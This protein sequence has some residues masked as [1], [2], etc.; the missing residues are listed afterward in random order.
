MVR[1]CKAGHHKR[2]SSKATDRTLGYTFQQLPSNLAI[3]RPPY[4]IHKTLPNPKT[5]PEIHPESSSK[6]EIQKKYTKL[7]DFR[8]FFV[9]F[10]YFGFGG[11]FGVYFGVYFGF[12]G[13][14]CILYGGRMITNQI[15]N[16][17]YLSV[18]RNDYLC[19]GVCSAYLKE[20]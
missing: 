13:V 16:D 7:G 15:F 5:H 1:D 12:G 20:F 2:S 14:L 18:V 19:I 4:K 9:F 17:A 10:L 11:G 8:I 3:M 6:T